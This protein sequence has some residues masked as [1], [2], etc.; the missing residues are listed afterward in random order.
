LADNLSVE[1]PDFDYIKKEAGPHTKDGMILL[2]T[3]A[4]DEAKQRRTG[5]RLAIERQEVKTLINSPAVSQDN[6]DTQFS[7]TLRFDGVVGINVTGIKARVEG[8]RVR[9]MVLGVGTITLKHN[10]ASSEAQNRILL[11]AAADKAVATNKS[12]ELEYQNARW[13]EIVLA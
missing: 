3:V 13:R 12:V 8:A 6:Y 7:T 10:S 11:F 9:V 5:I 4:N 1:A 2:W